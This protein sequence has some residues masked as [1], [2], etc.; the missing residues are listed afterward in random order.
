MV[1]L[2]DVERFVKE[3]DTKDRKHTDL[4]PSPDDTKFRCF[5]FA[6]QVKVR[7]NAKGIKCAIVIILTWNSK[8][9]IPTGNHVLN[10]FET[11]NGIVYYEP[12]DG[13]L[14]VDNPVVG[15]NL[16]ILFYDAYKKRNPNFVPNEDRD[17]IDAGIIRRKL[18]IW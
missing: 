11:D 13:G 15:E 10:A 18:E 5:D 2:A 17:Y 1:T 8:Y 9:E 14:F 4:V 16:H 3:D 12:Q 6:H 7:A